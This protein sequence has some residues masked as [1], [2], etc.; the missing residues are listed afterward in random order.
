MQN[1]DQNCAP[2]GEI[3]KNNL[4]SAP[5]SELHHIVQTAKIPNALLF[6]GAKGTGKKEAAMEFVKTCNCVSTSSRP[7]STCPSCKKIDS[8]MH[9]DMIFMGPAENKKIISIAQIREMGQR[10]SARPNEA[11]Y[12]MVCIKDADM[13][14]VQAQNGLL[15]VLE[16]PPDKTFFVLL[17]THTAPL[18]PTILS[19][20]RKFNFHPV[21][22]D[23]IRQI[24]TSQY[25]LDDKTAHIISG[26]SGS[27]L[28]KAIEYA[29]KA[30][31]DTFNWQAFR[32]WLINGLLDLIKGSR[33]V[34]I[35]KSIVLSQKL[36]IQPDRLNDAM[37]IIRT[38]L[39]DLCIFKYTPDQIVN[40]DFFDTFNDISGMHV[41]PTFLEWLTY[42]CDT[43]KRLASN[44]GQR[45]TLD[46]FFLKLSLSE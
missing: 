43:E 12:R 37:P 17:A 11:K 42:F 1:F 22:T 21:S 14:N 41:Y 28:E 36:T 7:C 35:S 10:I 6:S 33:Q 45:L 23:R 27:D 44:S 38:V 26:T 15:K 4:T 9:P 34:R 24:L 32:Q 46:S 16:E 3:L 19:R 2:A 31:D 25:D 18:L 13:M 39:R 20:C 8:G 29:G 40:L 30:Q 5:L